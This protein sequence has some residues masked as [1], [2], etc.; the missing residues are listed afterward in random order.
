MPVEGTVATMRYVHS[1]V[2]RLPVA[3]VHAW[4]DSDDGEGIGTRYMMLDWIEGG[5]LEWNASF[6][7]PAVRRKILGQLAQHSVDL[8][9]STSIQSSSQSALTWMLRKVDSRL[10]R[11]FSGNFP[12][13]DPID[14]LIFRAMAEEK[15]HIPILDALPFPLM[16]SDL[17]NMNFIVDDDYSINGYE[18]FSSCTISSC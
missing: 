1:A 12:S 15:Y 16:H 9:E 2:P 3:T 4:S 6:P 8:L 5:T 7:P 14:C 11:I 18:M 10:T 17:N 13:F